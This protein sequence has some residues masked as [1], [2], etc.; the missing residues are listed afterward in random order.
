MT[1]FVYIGDQE[2]TK[3]FGVLFQRG[4]PTTVNLD[5]EKEQERVVTKLRGNA[6]FTESVDGAEVMVQRKKPGRPRRLEA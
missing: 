4:E 5:D 3:V 1:Q 2:E 6:D